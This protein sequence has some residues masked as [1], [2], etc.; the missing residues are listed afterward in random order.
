MYVKVYYVR[1]RAQLTLHLCVV[2]WAGE[3]IRYV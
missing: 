3:G 1:C 2:I